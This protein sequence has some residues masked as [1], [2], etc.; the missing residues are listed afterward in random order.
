MA[1]LQ[2]SKADLEAQSVQ[3]LV[4][5]FGSFEG[6]QFWLEQTGC[7]FNMVLDGQRKVYRTFGLGSFYSK[8]M[9][10][11]VLLSYSEYG[12]KG[13]DFP[14]VPANL[15]EDIYQLGGDFM[16][17]EAGKVLLYYPSKNPRDRPSLKDI[18]QAATP[19][20]K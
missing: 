15:K 19:S 11:D 12:A 1:E 13:R 3:V 14:E 17:N 6:A 18:L 20:Q 8:V 10:F 7:I 4:V 5:A 2:A 16:L 9:K